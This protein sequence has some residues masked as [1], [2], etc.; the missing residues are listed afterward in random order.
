MRGVR[1]HWRDPPRRRAGRLRGGLRLV[2]ARRARR[3]S[4]ARPDP[5]GRHD[6][7]RARAS[8]SW[9][10]SWPTSTNWTMY[11][12][13]LGLILTFGLGIAGVLLYSR[14]RSGGAAGRPLPGRRHR[15]GRPTDQ[16]RPASALRLVLVGWL[17]NVTIGFWFLRAGPRSSRSS[18]WRRSS[19]R[20]AADRR[21]AAAP[22]PGRIRR[23]RTL[24]IVGA[25]IAF[26]HTA[27][28]STR[29]P[30]STTGSS[31]CSTSPGWSSS[32][33]GAGIGSA[34]GSRTLTEGRRRRRRP[35]RSDG[36]AG[37]RPGAR[38]RIGAPLPP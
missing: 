29:A 10:R 15:L 13:I 30:G 6:L 11:G 32:I 2:R 36:Q 34:E 14:P 12:G 26:Q 22:D 18:C 16:A 9:P 8:C 25:I 17:G 4:P 24:G 31:S 3:P 27:S 5:G 1:L 20:A 19:M 7:G 38:S 33:V 28:S 23:A 35:R 21:T 37:R